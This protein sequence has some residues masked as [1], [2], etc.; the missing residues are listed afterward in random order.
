MDRHDLTAANH[1]R[2]VARVSTAKPEGFHGERD[3]LR[4]AIVTGLRVGDTISGR[5]EVL[6]LVG[7]GGM[8]SVY[9][10]RDTSLD[11]L[12]A[13]KVLSRGADDELRQRLQREARIVASLNHP[14]I[15]NVFDIGVHDDTQF[16]VQEFLD[17]GDLSTV[18]TAPPG[19]GLP[20]AVAA[21]IAF[22]VAEA[23][24]FAHRNGVVHRDVKP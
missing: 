9:Q 22:A 18:L 19:K 20:R 13:V 5:Y 3:A 6:S 12:V 4:V 10:C 7:R 15:V 1:Q 23:L 11:R 17:G 21:K 16:I 8:S 14:G 2:I 24:A